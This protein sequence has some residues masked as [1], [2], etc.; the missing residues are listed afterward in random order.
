MLPRESWT[1]S[2]LLK[3]IHRDAI[4]RLERMCHGSEETIEIEVVSEPAL[5]ISFDLAY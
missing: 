1:I 3:I 4:Q 2:I 5:L